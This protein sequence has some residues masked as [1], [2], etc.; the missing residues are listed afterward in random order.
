MHIIQS[1]IKTEQQIYIEF[2]YRQT[3]LN[4]DIMLEILAIKHFALLDIIFQRSNKQPPDLTL[5]N[6]QQ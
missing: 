1:K 4:M 3:L 6:C 2:S 5:Q